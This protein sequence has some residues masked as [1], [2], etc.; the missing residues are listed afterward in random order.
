MSSKRFIPQ[1]IQCYG[2]SGAAEGALEP[3]KE[4]VA[5][6]ARF[7]GAWLT[8]YMIRRFGPPNCPSDDHKN[9]CSWT[10]TTPVPGLALLVTPYLADL[11]DDSR[12]SLHFGYRWS[13]KLEKEVG[14][15]D[16][17]AKEYRA[18]TEKLWRWQR[19]RFVFL[20]TK[21]GGGRKLIETF[22]S[23]EDGESDIGL[24][25]ASPSGEKRGEFMTKK[26]FRHWAISDVILKEYR[27]AYPRKPQ[28]KTAG[29][30]WPTSA[31]ARRCNFALRA[32]IRALMEPVSVR[33]LDF[34]ATTGYL[35]NGCPSRQRIAEP[36]EFA[37]YA[38]K[39]DR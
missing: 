21:D 19:G 10:I 6:G 37:G 8:A 15:L 20:Y 16:P 7:H 1:P 27:K 4:A 32:A 24:Y 12:M 5:I 9:L 17:G 28:K 3:R 11:G 31:I 35:P 33:D 36:F 14:R 29:G 22:G 23:K 18:L 38:C 26:C 34:C 39:V 30:T 2:W 25:R 13:K